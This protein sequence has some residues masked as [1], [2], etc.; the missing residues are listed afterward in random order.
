MCK[1][2][3]LIMSI[4]LLCGCASLNQTQVM[5]D[6]ARE[7]KEGYFANPKDKIMIL[8]EGADGGLPWANC[9]TSFGTL[10]DSGSHSKSFTIMRPYV[11]IFDSQEIVAKLK[12]AIIDVGYN[13]LSQLDRAKLNLKLAS[14]LPQYVYTCQSEGAAGLSGKIY[15]DGKEVSSDINNLD[16]G[17]ISLRYSMPPEIFIPAK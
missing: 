14:S 15:F 11:Q 5:L 4:V 16:Y 12:Q 1:A 7:E 8:I 10:S 13:K 17:V 9:T 6:K 3:S 2:L